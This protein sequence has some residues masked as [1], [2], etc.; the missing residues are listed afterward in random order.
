MLLNN[1]GSSKKITGEI[2]K[3]LQELPWWQAQWLRIHLPVQGT[4]VQSLA[5][6]DSTCRGAAKP[7]CHSYWACTL[8][9]MSH[10]YWSL[11]A[12][13]P[14]RH[15]YW[16]H[17]V[18]LPKPACS[19]ARVPQLLSPW[20]LLACLE[21]E[22]HNE[23]SHWNEKPVHRTATKSSPYLLQLEKACTQQWRPNAAKNKQKNPQNT[24][25]QMKTEI[26]HTKI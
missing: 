21:P 3:C 1:N 6:E 15:N 24:Y 7:M 4:W 8:E 20:A 16:A 13:E 25:R 17:A 9:P 26:L 14:T 10:N 5:R 2:R 22:L 11:C 12:L 23:R 18:Q 19:R